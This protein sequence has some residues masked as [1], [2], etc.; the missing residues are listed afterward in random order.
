MNCDNN[1]NKPRALLLL[2]I[3]LLTA[4]QWPRTNNRCKSNYSVKK[5]TRCLETP[6]QGL[7]QQINLHTGDII[8]NNSS[9]NITKNGDKNLIV[10]Y[11]LL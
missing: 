3:L 1:I 7:T 5:L 9:N 8:Y 4:N 2:L 6:I 11:F 10:N